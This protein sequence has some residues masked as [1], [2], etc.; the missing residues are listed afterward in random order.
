MKRLML[1]ALALLI[2]ATCAA[3]DPPAIMSYSYYCT[4]ENAERSVAALRDFAKREKGYMKNFTSNAAVMRVPA[5]SIGRL[6][7][8]LSRLGYIADERT[9]RTDI[10]AEITE[11]E[12][13]LA[14]KKKLLAELNALFT[15]STFHQ[16]IEIERE[17]G[18]V[19]IEIERIRGQL[20]MRRDQAGLAEIAVSMNQ[21]VPAGQ[22]KGTVPAAWIK[23]LGIEPLMRDWH[24]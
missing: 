20:A 22:S 21:K 17:I 5:G 18:N 10:S 16:T 7:E 15:G 6:R 1:S 4:V 8:L 24:E 14:V 9:Q 23:G 3:A 19:I 2:A 12:T 13:Q 11:L